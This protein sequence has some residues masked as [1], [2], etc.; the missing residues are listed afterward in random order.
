MTI[1]PD[2][3]LKFVEKILKHLPEPDYVTV[4]LFQKMVEQ[5]SLP[6][7]KGLM[8]DLTQAE[9]RVVEPTKSII[10]A[11]LAKQYEHI[12]LEEASWSFDQTVGTGSMKV[13][14]LPVSVTLTRWDLKIAYTRLTPST[15]KYVEKL[16]KEIQGQV[17]LCKT[18]AIGTSLF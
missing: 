17:N 11:L 1:V 10:L 15:R 8:L 14:I 2:L 13:N 12:E 3:D 18:T 6:A 4:G 9:A 16:E 7:T 5:T